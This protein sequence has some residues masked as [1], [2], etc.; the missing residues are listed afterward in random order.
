MFP[1]ETGCRHAKIPFKTG[2]LYY[3]RTYQYIYIYI[4]MRICAPSTN[5]RIYYRQFSH[6]NTVR[7]IKEN[8][9]IIV[10][11]VGIILACE[12]AGLLSSRN[13]LQHHHEQGKQNTSFLAYFVFIGAGLSIFPSIHLCFFCRSERL[14]IM[15]GYCVYH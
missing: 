12:T 14:H 1:L 3:I 13:I 11:R 15:A 9:R 10:C 2:S 5:I 8:S 6:Q 7:S 4:Y